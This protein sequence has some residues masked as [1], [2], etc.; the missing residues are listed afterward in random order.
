[1]IDAVLEAAPRALELERILAQG[2]VRSVYQPIVDLD[3]GEVV[4]YEALARGPE[5]S[6]LERP[7]RLFAAAREAG[8]VSDLDWACRA[9]ALRGALDA[10]LKTWR[11]TPP[12]RC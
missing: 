10:R 11:A 8:R 4:A 9:A 5:G 6:P 1:M 7:D 2:L 12:A 3:T